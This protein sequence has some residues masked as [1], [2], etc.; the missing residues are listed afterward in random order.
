MVCVCF[1]ILGGAESGEDSQRRSPALD[2]C[3]SHGVDGGLLG[4][5]WCCYIN[6]V[7]IERPQR[8]L[9]LA[10]NPHFLFGLSD[11]EMGGGARRG[12]AP[13]PEPEPGALPRQES[14]GGAGRANVHNIFVHDGTPLP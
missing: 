2:C 10:L 5:E 4:C 12:A 9:G 13:L 11:P 14:K 6:F 7:P 1:R 3:G 8:T